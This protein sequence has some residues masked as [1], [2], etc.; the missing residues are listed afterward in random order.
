MK[1][2]PDIVLH[3]KHTLELA[4]LASCE[5]NI[6]YVYPYALFLISWNASENQITQRES[7]Y[8]KRSLETYYNKLKRFEIIA[9]D[10]DRSL[11]V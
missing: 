10:I 11:I 2:N 5:E 4:L 9:R 3:L 1:S 8:L 7:V 6:D